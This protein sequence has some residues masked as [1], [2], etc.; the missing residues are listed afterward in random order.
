MLCRY[1]L[2]YI[3]SGKYGHLSYQV[4]VVVEVCPKNFHIAGYFDGEHHRPT[5]Q[6]FPH[7]P[8]PTYKPT[9]SYKHVS[10]ILTKATPP[11][12]HLL[13]S[14]EKHRC[15]RRTALLAAPLDWRSLPAGHRELPK[16]VAVPPPPAK[17]GAPRPARA[18]AAAAKESEQKRR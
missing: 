9:R 5:F 4:P 11:L 13:P 16:P 2:Q 12:F 6:H 7:Q 15:R 10:K 8:H 17:R 3:S 14:H 18:A 1:A